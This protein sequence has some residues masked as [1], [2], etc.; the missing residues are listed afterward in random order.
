MGRYRQPITEAAALALRPSERLTLRAS[1]AGQKLSPL[2]RPLKSGLQT[3]GDL[4]GVA[5]G[6]RREEVALLPG[7]ERGDEDAG[8]Q[9]DLRH[10]GL[11]RSR[12]IA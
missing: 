3:A 5:C 11:R 2:G 1:E 6:E 8:V 9:D 4:V 10:A 7:Y 12:R